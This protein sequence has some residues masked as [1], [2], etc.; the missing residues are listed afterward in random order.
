MFRIRHKAALTVLLFAG[1]FG[2]R[3]AV[4]GGPSTAAGEWLTYGGDLANTRYSPLNQIDA[5]NF[6]KLELAWR[7][8]TDN[9]GP[10][11]EFKLEGTP[12]MAG[13][14]LY[15]T[16]GTRRA[17]VALDAATGEL[18]WVHGEDEGARG[19]AGP[20]QLSGRGLSY[21]SDGKEARILYITH[22][23]P[24]RRARCQDRLA[25][26]RLWQRWTRRP[27]GAGDRRRRSED[28]AGDRRNRRQQHPAHRRRRRGRR[29]RVFGAER[30]PADDA[31]QFQRPRPRVRHPHRQT[32]V[33]LP[34]DS[35]AGRVRQR[36]AGRKIPGP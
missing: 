30:H 5:G 33:D 19:N 4:P 12:L 7:F 35:D 22:R 27:E 34:D 26:Q 25:R 31:Q 9:L 8:R 11:P 21:W 24:T 29:L 6:S 15:A 2:A 13:G 17:V 23:L 10:R 20:R 16:A 28:R 36:D 14:L 32:A 3:A 18:R 1:A